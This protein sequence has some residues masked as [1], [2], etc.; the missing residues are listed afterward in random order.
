MAKLWGSRSA[1]YQHFQSKI[2]KYGVE[3]FRQFVY[4]TPLNAP[5]PPKYRSSKENTSMLYEG[6]CRP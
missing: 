4:Q 1:F 3:C 6:E 2:C 5:P